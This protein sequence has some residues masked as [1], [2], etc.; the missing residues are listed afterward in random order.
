M[1][2]LVVAGLLIIGDK[3]CFRVGNAIFIVVVAQE[4]DVIGLQVPSDNALGIADA[5][6]YPSPLEI[7]VAVRLVPSPCVPL[8]PLASSLVDLS[9]KFIFSFLKV[10]E[11]ARAPRR[12]SSAF[13]VIPCFYFC[14][15]PGRRFDTLAGAISEYVTG[16]C[17]YLLSHSLSHFTIC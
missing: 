12:A 8:F 7:Y 15:V 13:D 9:S 14:D 6:V 3:L 16:L 10:H 11:K 2:D 4:G 1:G 17:R 5:R